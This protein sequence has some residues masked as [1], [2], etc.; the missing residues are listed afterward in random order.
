MKINL[1]DDIPVYSC[2]RRLSYSDKAEV[3]EIIDDLLASAIVLVKKRLGEIRMCEFVII[4]L[5]H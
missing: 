2:P 3:Q 4:F 1:V 5:C